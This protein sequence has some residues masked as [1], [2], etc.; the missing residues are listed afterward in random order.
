MGLLL[1][2]L[3]T[4][5]YGN[6][7]NTSQIN[8][9]ADQLVQTLRSTR[10]KSVA[11]LGGVA[12]GVKFE[13]NSGPAD[14]YIIYRGVTYAGRNTS[15]ERAVILPAAIN[16]TTS[17]VGAEINFATASGTPSTTGDV[18][19]THGTYGAKRVTISV[20]GLVE[21]LP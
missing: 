8:A 18:T 7:Q 2:A 4:P 17:L 16:L 13:E 1:A 11:G 5:I 15:F 10:E 6:L 14:R 3:A 21:L 12:H 19:L 20:S 9:E